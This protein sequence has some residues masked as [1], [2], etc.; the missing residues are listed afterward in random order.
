MNIERLSISSMLNVADTVQ[1]PNYALGAV[2]PSIVHFGAGNFHRAHQA[3]YCDAL[4]NQGETRWGITGVSLRS[5]KM[6][7]NLAPQ[8]CLYT[9]AILGEKETR[10]RVVG[11][12]QNMA[13]GPENPQ[14]LIDLLASEPTQLVT[15]T[16]TEKGYYLKNGVID[17]ESTDIANDLAS[18]TAPKTTYG[19]LAAGLIKRASKGDSPIT[20][21]CCDNMNAGGER[22]RDGVHMLLAK[23]SP[24]TVSWVN[25]NVAFSASMVDRVTPA[26]DELL[27]TEVAQELGVQDAAPVAA[28]PFTQW[29]IEDNF[30]GDRPPFDKVGALFVDDIAPFERV[31][32]RFL[33]AGHSMLAA[34][35]YLVGD[36]F[37]HE[38]L[39]R[40]TLAQFTEQ[41]LKLNVMP[42]TSVP[43]GLQAEHYIA[44]VFARF[45]N[46]NLPYAALQ[47][48]TDSSQKIQQ[49]WFPSIDDALKQSVDTRYLAFAVAAWVCFI[50]KALVRGDLNDPLIDEFT[51]SSSTGASSDVLA[52]LTLAGANKFSFFSDT[53]FMASVHGYHD[54]INGMG[55]EEAI[56]H[57]FA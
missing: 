7:D 17:L 52:F 51:N 53:G 56:V 26:T 11:A 54:Y 13:V 36:R 49:R 12:I 35:G 55:V 8:N 34:L 43:D 50:H 16:I 24:E 9:L 42:V 1:K 23:H 31:K 57:C 39:K 37:I 21:L 14:A 4:L 33:N 10:F 19:Y 18:L 45:R 5:A 47:V 46:G 6:R 48:G 25:E 30:A 44:Q 27:K 20:L 3:A 32:L 22:L 38:A 40:P 28:E 2:L 29:I 41:A 15:T